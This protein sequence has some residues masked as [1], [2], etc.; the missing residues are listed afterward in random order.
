MSAVK[1]LQWKRS[2][3]TLRFS[4]E[5]LEYITEV[6][7]EA[8]TEF[9]SYYRRF[10]AENNIDIPGLEQENK[11]R[12]EQYYDHQKLPDS[13]IN[14]SMISGSIGDTSLTLYQNGE[15]DEEY[16]MSADEIAIH[17][18]FTKLFKKIALKLHPDRVSEHLPDDEKRIRSEH[19]KEAN[20]ALEQ[21]K[22]FYLLD[23]AEKYGVSTPRNYKQQT[24]WMK[25]ETE[26]IQQLIS[27]E[28]NTYNYGFAE[29]ETEEEKIN[30]IKKF[31][32]QLFRVQ[33]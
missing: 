11:D 24:R 26:K 18:A 33:V 25:R 13:D 8:A 30:L 28:K 10:C 2:L 16:Q 27:K 9:E 32:Y 20:E 5:E 12:M 21:R 29:A 17:E 4:Y 7:R 31:I 15:Q 3:S 23:I 14:D 19:F 1:N 6:S 22:Y